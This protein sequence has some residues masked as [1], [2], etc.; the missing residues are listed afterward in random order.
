MT[1]SLE[2]TIISSH[3]TTSS[4]T[5]ASLQRYYRC[6][7]RAYHRSTRCCS[8]DFTCVAIFYCYGGLT[9]SGW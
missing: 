6:C 7:W 4:R 9:T 1:Y 2:L 5:T 3:S 8:S